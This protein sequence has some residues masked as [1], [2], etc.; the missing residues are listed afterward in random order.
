M[1]GGIVFN[2]Y[3]FAAL[4]AIITGCCAYEFYKIIKAVRAK[5]RLNA[6]YS[7]IGIVTAVAFFICGF[8]VAKG[9]LD[10]KWLTLLSLPLL[11][12]F[13]V[14]LS[15]KSK[16]PFQNIGLN[17]TGI[18]Y[19]G[20]P[21]GLI[22]SIVLVNGEFDGMRLMWIIILIW[23]NDT[24]AFFAGSL[25]G[26]HKLFERISPKKTIE[27]FIGSVVIT[28]GVAIGLS[29]FFPVYSLINWI[30]I[31]LLVVCFA[32]LGDLIESMLKR[33]LGI[34]DSGNVMPG[35]G[36]FLDRFDAVLFSVPFIS[37]YLLLFG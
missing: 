12:L 33:S 5:E 35:H 10:V 23:I 37:V 16:N 32:T 31:A 1:V 20:I 25:F 15:S 19:I 8:F 27:G 3:G 6:N 9:E 36:G 30:V 21:M 17:L 14:E 28:I 34:K 24:A 22:S 11:A 7:T 13:I 2:Q 26:K 18:L 29:F 4:M